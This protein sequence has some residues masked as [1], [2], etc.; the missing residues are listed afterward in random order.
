MEHNLKVNLV[1]EY[2]NRALHA[3]TSETSVSI[4][5]VLVNGS[6]DP[7]IRNKKQNTP[8]CN[9]LTSTNSE[10]VKCLTKKADLDIIGGNW[11]GPLHI[12]CIYPADL[13]LVNTLVDAGA[14]VNLVDLV[15]G[16]P[17]QSACSYEGSSKEEQESAIL[18]LINKV[19]MDLG[20]I[21]GLHGCAL[22]AACG[23]TSFEIVRLMLVEFASIDVRDDMGR[24]AIHFAAA[25]RMENFQATL[26][27][28]ADVE[29]ADNMGRTALHWASVWR[30]GLS[31][32]PH[33]IFVEGLRRSG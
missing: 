15:L 2:G 7:N 5:K 1:D 4:A 25:R 6:A 10:I 29:M 9:A 21:G 20:I 26:E 17:L 22:N 14:D 11:G 19:K 24:M 18:Y 8:L 32:Q 28:G 27:S 33:H 12:A 13:H 31:C 3:I 16:T 30:Y 23:G